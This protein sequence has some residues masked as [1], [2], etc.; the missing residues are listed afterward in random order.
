VESREAI[1]LT[2]RSEALFLDPTYTAKAMAGLIS[3]VRRQAFD[4]DATVLFW[5]TGGQVALF[6]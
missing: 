5:H 2:A 1:E 4:K 3:R 6:A